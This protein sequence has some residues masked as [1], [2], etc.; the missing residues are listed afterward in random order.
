MRQTEAESANPA[1]TKRR[2]RMM[3]TL[4]SGNNQSGAPT[5]FR[6]L[7]QGHHAYA[8]L[9]PE[10]PDVKAWNASAESNVRKRGE[11]K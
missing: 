8:V 5:R 2:S 10:D 4:P 11:G 3:I 1:Q 6:D 7:I 9:H